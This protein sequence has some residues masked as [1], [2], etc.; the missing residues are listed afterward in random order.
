MQRWVFKENV[1]ALPFKSDALAR[2][3][4]TT[5]AELDSEPVSDLAADVVFDALAR[6][7]SG[8]VKREECDERRTSYAANG[9]KMALTL[10]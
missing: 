9:A 10:S 8:I 7:V 1:A 5:A 2:S 3:V 4:G 6:S